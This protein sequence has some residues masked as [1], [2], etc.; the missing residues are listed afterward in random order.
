LS[1]NVTWAILVR[2]N[3]P[4]LAVIRGGELALVSFTAVAATPGLGVRRAIDALIQAGVSAIGYV[5]MAD[6]AAE[7]AARSADV[8]LIEL[9][10]GQPLRNLETVANR[11]LTERRHDAYTEAQR[12]YAELARLA[13]DGASV[14]RVLERLADRARCSCAVLDADLV[15]RAAWPR[16]DG[17]FEQIGQLD[18][19]RRDV[20]SWVDRLGEI[21]A[22]P[23][24]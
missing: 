4:D 8:P 18:A 3:G 7:D 24:T 9:P 21:P 1:R 12:L 17:S 15:P 22:E 6:G 5:G 19:A 23:P 20:L 14:E 13:L 2:T 16:L 10:S 11:F